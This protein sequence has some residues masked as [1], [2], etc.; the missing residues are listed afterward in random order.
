MEFR[1]L[2]PLEVVHRG[3]PVRLVRPKERAVLALLLLRANDLVSCDR[4]IDE[5][6]GERAPETA[7]HTLEAYISRLRGIFA[8]VGGSEL[9]ERRAGGYVIHVAPG[10][11][12]SERFERLLEEGEEALASGAAEHADEKLREALGLW[13]GEVLSDLVFE[14]LPAAEI[15]RLDELRLVA[16]E[17]Q[18][19]AALALGRDGVL[20][21]EL[22]MLVSRYPLRERLRAQLMLAL[23][24]L[25]RQAEAIDVYVQGKELLAEQLGID[26]D[27]DLQRLYAQ[28]LRHDATLVAPSHH[29]QSVPQM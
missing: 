16:I 15:A 8:G 5:L 14:P 29:R 18:V 22:H 11:L 12:D 28:I 20:V 9:I 26:P 6:W 10:Q 3:R 1:L 17:A 24:R 27:P 4:L 13:R 23:Y 21:A 7:R 2:G 25:G 19:E